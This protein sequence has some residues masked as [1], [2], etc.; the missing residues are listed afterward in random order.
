MNKL[1][2]FLS[3][4]SKIDIPVICSVNYPWVYI[5]SIKGI[6]VE[7]KYGS[8]YGWVLGYLKNN[9]EEFQFTDVKEIFKLIRKYE[10]NN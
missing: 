5:E 1:L 7:E 4:L 10:N 9:E 6:N 8:E 2:T 3:R